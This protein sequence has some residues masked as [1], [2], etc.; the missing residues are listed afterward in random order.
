[1]IELL[2]SVP[3]PILASG[4]LAYGLIGACFSSGMSE[5]QFAHFMDCQQCR[6][7]LSSQWRKA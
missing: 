1:M 7:W 6:T 3:L 4:C 2:K 5:D